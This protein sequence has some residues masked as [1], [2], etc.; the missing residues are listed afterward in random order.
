LFASPRK[1]FKSF[2]E[3]ARRLSR[4]YFPPFL[5]R[6]WGIFA[7][8]LHQSPEV[9]RAYNFLCIVA[10]ADI[11]EGVHYVGEIESTQTRTIS[12]N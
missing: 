10:L 3:Q 11:N 8:L 2:Y 4:Q 7:S 9:Y 12:V 1:C 6:Q 5:V